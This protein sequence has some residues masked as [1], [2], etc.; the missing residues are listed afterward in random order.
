MGC[1]DRASVVHHGGDCGLLGAGGFLVAVG[2][3]GCRVDALSLSDVGGFRCGWAGG[4]GHLGAIPAGSGDGCSQCWMVDVARWNRT[5]I[6]GNRT[7][8]T[9]DG[10]HTGDVLAIVGRAVAR[11][12]YR[13]ARSLAFDLEALSVLIGRRAGLHHSPC[14]I[15]LQV[16]TAGEVLAHVLV[17]GLQIGLA[18]SGIAI[19]IEVFLLLH[20]LRGGLGVG[21]LRLSVPGR[22]GFVAILGKV[23]LRVQ[24]LL[25]VLGSGDRAG[26]LRGPIRTL[27]LGEVPAGDLGVVAGLLAGGLVPPGEVGDEL[28]LR[29]HIFFDDLLVDRLGLGTA[30]WRG[31]LPTQIARGRA[32]GDAGIA[33][34]FVATGR[35]VVDRTGDQAIGTGEGQRWAILLAHQGGAVDLQ[36]ATLCAFLPDI[37]VTVGRDDGVVPLAG[38]H[39]GVGVRSHRR[40][41]AVVLAGVVTPDAR[42]RF[43]RRRGSTGL[44]GLNRREPV[45]LVGSA[46]VLDRHELAVVVGCV[47]IGDGEEAHAEV[48]V[49]RS[50]RQADRRLGHVDAGAVVAVP[51]RKVLLLRGGNGRA[52]PLAR[53]R[54]QDAAIRGHPGDVGALRQSAIVRLDRG[55]TGFVAGA[56]NFGGVFEMRRGSAGDGVG[57]PVEVISRLCQVVVE[58]AAA[59]VAVIS[60][61]AGGEIDRAQALVVA[62][63]PCRRERGQWHGVDAVGRRREAVFGQ[64]VVVERV[65]ERALVAHREVGR[66]VHFPIVGHVRPL[67]R[68]RRVEQQHHIG[69]VLVGERG[70]RNV[71]DV[72]GI[73]RQRVGHCETAA[74]H[75]G[76]GRDDPQGSQQSG[77]P[78]AHRRGVL[79]W[80]VRVF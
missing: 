42:Q 26:A 5:R 57:Y 59:G 38:G 22:C 6:R 64:R 63:F 29:H 24:N 50:K 49:Q 23:D 20:F 7:A 44:D 28:I 13:H 25:L 79:A 4:I 15:A 56:G 46:K 53:W 71:R 65:A 77:S 78:C 1:G 76:N 8:F 10:A 18:L 21:R 52:Y 32:I 3:R 60:L 74:D 62:V 9:G 68:V 39:H 34:H 55:N 54:G 69:L 27:A 19:P 73:R 47:G 37:P 12:G 75:A 51:D 11:V 33:H 70:H 43:T 16:T 41:D 17:G 31:D 66:G 61:K 48:I 80:L 30:A 58:I 36:R 2:L 45:D 67:H 72:H 35:A 14:V 40:V